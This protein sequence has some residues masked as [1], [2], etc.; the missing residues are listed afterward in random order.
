M[1]Q[2][3]GLYVRDR[4]GALLSVRAL[5]VVTMPHHPLCLRDRALPWAARVALI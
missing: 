4:G 3:G 1:K 2:S 5:A